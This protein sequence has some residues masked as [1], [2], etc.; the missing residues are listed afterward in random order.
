MSAA[1]QYQEKEEQELY[2]NIRIT[3]EPTN[4]EIKY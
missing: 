4:N 2:G 1:Q 3:I